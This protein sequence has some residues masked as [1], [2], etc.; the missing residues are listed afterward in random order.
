V[1]WFGSAFDGSTFVGRVC[2]VPWRCGVERARASVPRSE[3]EP[4]PEPEHEL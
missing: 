1:F 2:V 4:E 3:P